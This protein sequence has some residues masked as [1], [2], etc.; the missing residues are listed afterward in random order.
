MHADQALRAVLCKSL[1]TNSSSNQSETSDM[2]VILLCLVRLL[3][4]HSI[5]VAA[6]Y[7]DANI[8][9]F[10]STLDDI[11]TILSTFSMDLYYYQSLKYEIV[12]ILMI[13]YYHFQNI[14]TH[15]YQLKS[16][17]KPYTEQS[18]ITVLCN[19]LQLWYWIRV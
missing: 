8:N 7:S 4:I 3:Q 6:K 5:T 19:H 9:I 17:V 11:N 15:Q 18:S 10:I 14:I 1:I 16:M 2:L 13:L 12:N